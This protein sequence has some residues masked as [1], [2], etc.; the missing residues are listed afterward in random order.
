MLR[1]RFFPGLVVGL[2][3]GLPLGAIVAVMLFPSHS[4]TGATTAEIVE[5]S[6]R[7]AD[8]QRDKESLN[9]QIDEFRTLAERMTASFSELERRFKTMEDE[10]GHGGQ[11]PP[12]ATIAPSAPVS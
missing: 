7:L 5:L 8:A 2:L 9:R 12:T 10:L 11:V 3:L 6:R 1:L 4:D